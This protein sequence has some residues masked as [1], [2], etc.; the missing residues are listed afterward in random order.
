MPVP[1]TRG[2]KPLL[3]K[4]QNKGKALSRELVEQCRLPYKTKKMLFLIGFMGSG[5][6]TTGQQLAKVVGADFQDLDEIIE[7]AE[8]QTIAQIFDNRGEHFFREIESH[9]LKTIQEGEH[10]KVV[11]VGGGTPCFLDNMDWMNTNGTTIF[12]NPTVDILFNRLK[13]ETA[14]RPILAGKTDETL[15][16]FITEK[17][18]SRLH[19]Y[20]KA[21]IV[22]D[23][24]S[25]DFNV[26]R[27]I[28][29]EIYAGLRAFT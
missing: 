11:A 22:I 2:A 1:K 20:K 3:K 19:F 25:D 8:N 29:A 12:L 23:I 7:T 10:P 5:K 15:R 4:I 28:I 24:E 14:H 18:N 9:H 26:I 21:N 6:S 13:S 17:L 27:K 16:H